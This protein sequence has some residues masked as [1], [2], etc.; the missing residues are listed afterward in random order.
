MFFCHD[1]AYSKTAFKIQIIAQELYSTS[2][3]M[4]DMLSN[5]TVVLIRMHTVYRTHQSISQCMCMTCTCFTRMCPSCVNLDHISHIYT[6]MLRA[7]VFGLWLCSVESVHFLNDNC[8]YVLEGNN[9]NMFLKE[10]TLLSAEE[11]WTSG[12]NWMRPAQMTAHK[13]DK[14]EEVLSVYRNGLQWIA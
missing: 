3:C 7:H 8:K 12:R 11:L 6:H 4:L 14:M 1:L 2:S 13:I 10:I 5:A 9:A